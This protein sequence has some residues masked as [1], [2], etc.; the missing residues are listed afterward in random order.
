MNSNKFI[1]ITTFIAVKY[2]IELLITNKLRFLAIAKI[3]EPTID[4]IPA[5]APIRPEQ[6]NP[7]PIYLAADKKFCKNILLIDSV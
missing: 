2:I 4:P 5:P 1:I 6:A 7:A 3:K